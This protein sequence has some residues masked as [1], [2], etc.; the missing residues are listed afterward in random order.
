MNLATGEATE[1]GLI[2]N[3]VSEH[4]AFA[5]QGIAFCDEPVSWIS[6]PE[7]IGSTNY[8]GTSVVSVDVD[9]TGLA[10]GVY[11]ADICINSNDPDEPITI[12]PVL[13]NVNDIIFSD[14][15]E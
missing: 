1:V 13:V 8:G 7:S 10:L 15:F 6:L 5:I 9:T 3:Q 4:T 12:V 11:D 2:G 14:G